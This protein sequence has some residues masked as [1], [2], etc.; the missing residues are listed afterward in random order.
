M[1]VTSGL[2]RGGL[3][4]TRRISGALGVRGGNGR[5][6]RWSASGPLRVAILVI[7][8]LGM[9]HMH[10]QAY[11]NQ[12]FS[13]ERREAITLTN[14]E[15]D[16][17]PKP[18]D[19]ANGIQAIKGH[20][21]GLELVDK[22]GDELTPPRFKQHDADA[23]APRD[24]ISGAPAVKPQE[25]KAESEDDKVFAIDPNAQV[26]T[27]E[28]PLLQHPIVVDVGR[29]DAS[30]AGDEP[31]AAAGQEVVT[32]GNQAKPLHPEQDDDEHNGPH[33]DEHDTQQEPPLENAENAEN[34]DEKPATEG[35]SASSPPVVPALGVKHVVSLQPVQ[36]SL[37]RPQNEAGTPSGPEFM[38]IRGI[39]NDLPPRH[40]VGQS[41]ENVKF[42]LDNE[43]PLEGLK[44]MWLIN[45]IVNSTEEERIV[46]LLESYNQ[47][48]FRIAVDVNEYAKRTVK[49]EGFP[50]PDMIRSKYYR[51]TDDQTRALAMDEMHHQK[52]LYVMNN[53][54]ARNT[55][56]RL[57][58]EAG[59]KWILP[60]DGNCFFTTSAWESIRSA[61]REEGGR[62][63]YFT[64]P[65]ARLQ[66]NSVLMDPNFR[67]DAMEEPQVMFRYD[68]SER[69]DENMRYGRRPKVE[70]L[71]RLGVKGPW[72]KW[73]SNLLWNN[74]AYDR[75][76][77]A[78]DVIQDGKVPPAGWVARLYSGKGKL[79]VGGSIATRGV[80]RS[81]GIQRLLN[82]MDARVAYELHGFTKDTLLSYDE[83]VLEKERTA[84]RTNRSKSL[85]ALVNRL[86][87]CADYAL[88]QGPWSV[89]DKTELP[90]SRDK[91][92]YYTP[93]PYF[94]PNPKT[95]D[96]LPYVRRD[97]QRVP[98]TELYDEQSNKFDRTRLAALYGNTTCLGLGWYF[99][100]RT[101][102]AQKIADNVRTWFLN[103]A[104]AMSP[105][106]KYSQ[107]LWGL[108]DN[109]GEPTG[110]IEFKDFYYF[111]DAVRLAHRAGALTDVEMDGLRDWF[112][113]YQEYLLTSPQGQGEYNS[114]NNHGLYF[115]V[116]NLAISAFVGEI[117]QFVFRAHMAKGRLLGQIAVDGTMPFEMERKTQLHYMMFT[118]QGWY[119]L[120]RMAHRAGINVFNFKRARADF[121]SLK[122]ST[123]Y[124]V[125]Y[126]KS[127]FY[128]YQELET[129]MARALPLYY[130]AVKYYPEMAS[131]PKCPRYAN[132]TPLY[133]A[134]PLFYEHD[135]IHPFWNL[136][137]TDEYLP[138]DLTS[139]SQ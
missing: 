77:I 2:G 131:R 7:I 71:W 4:I 52:N 88:T 127:T 44:E 105:H 90:P 78:A 128:H 19:G 40:K 37:T 83:R 87:T 134:K 30:P 91:H 123:A 25:E 18:A 60:F 135:G 112:R 11:G 53:N 126:F 48:Y 75:P 103:P 106:T 32:E 36:K 138:A 20:G 59:A 82:Q 115:D 133:Q 9:V 65:M 51:K 6:I 110:V 137:L 80:H 38:L 132:V 12:E 92:D 79:E 116:Q 67:P 85:V 1:A 108:N 86:K 13:R 94:W 55:M 56:I 61:V 68:A 54:G 58:L 43:P 100:G 72:D 102:Y 99:T 84:Y 70:L 89:M 47:T 17:A 28:D 119:H 113:K 26:R 125:P 66:D 23:D 3:A 129:D 63:K 49:Y 46:G 124:T 29:N 74:V 57:G 34:A 97:G 130:M 16:D 136:G 22:A 73:P 69:Y 120:G 42:I 39:G 101:D 5:A 8:L 64:V 35:D 111:L 122:K 107:I 98:G 96:G 50:F 31:A 104:T 117:D 21:V 93:K 15:A 109:L 41:Y 81:E 121:P 95:K 76:K 139:P 114:P 118:L 62:T 14:Q 27:E 10:R 45:H 24:G 33:E